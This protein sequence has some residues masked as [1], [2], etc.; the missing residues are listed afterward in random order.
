MR[1]IERLS[2]DSTP[3]CPCQ[4]TDGLDL[5][6]LPLLLVCS[7]LCLQSESYAGTLGLKVCGFYQGNELSDDGSLH[8]STKKV[9]DSVRDRSAFPRACLLLLDNDAF[10]TFLSGET[11]DR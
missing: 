2:S 11:A 10:T 5:T 8:A 3:A 4:R 6:D 9:G 1:S 7:F